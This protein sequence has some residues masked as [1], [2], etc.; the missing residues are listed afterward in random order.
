M[1][2]SIDSTSASKV[3]LHPASTKHIKLG[4]P[5]ITEDSYS[6]RFPK[7][8]FFLLAI[9]DSSKSEVGLFI[10]D[11]E[12]KN[13]K[14]RLWSHNPETWKKKND[15]FA[16]LES[17]IEIALKKR[18]NSHLNKE[19]ENFYLI[20]AESDILPGLLVLLLKD[21]IIIQY[22]ALFWKKVE[23]ELLESINKKMNEI[24][25]RLIV[26]DIW[27]QER[28]FNQQKV[29]KS[30]R[31]QTHL[32]YTLNEF[33]LNYHIRLNEHYDMGIYTDMSA[34]RKQ[35]KSYLEKAQSMLNLFCYTGAFSLYGM[36]LGIKN[37]VSVDLSEKYLAWLDSN[38][39][40]NPQL[41]KSH[42]SSLCMPTEKA[43]QKLIADKKEFDAIICDPPSASSDG[44]TTTNAFKAYEKLLP[45]LLELLSNNGMLFVFLNTHAISWN[46]FE[47][48][49]KQ[50][51]ATTRFQNSV[52][53]GKRFKLSEDCAPLK[54]FH[55][56]DYLKGFLLEFKNHQKEK[57]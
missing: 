33:D 1:T 45:L 56:G 40:L 46:K 48:K 29:I 27:I 51:I 37:V 9:D 13:V 36:K 18:A 49:L 32:E 41:N 6:K 10:N 38:I 4:H 47:D 30:V 3:A 55:E 35:M 20:N 16:E 11:P 57:K 12:H 44:Q 53:V 15:F 54:G 34:N 14:A 23:R 8:A 52:T 39:E 21:Q 24:F 26:Q 7:N 25:P 22:Y 17:R 42:H 31:G 5:W 50:I 28:N 19:R 2:L 43:L